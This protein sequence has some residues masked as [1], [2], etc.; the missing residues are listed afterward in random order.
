LEERKRESVKKMTTANWF[1]GV[2]RRQTGACHDVHVIMQ[3]HTRQKVTIK[4]QKL[5]TDADR[6]VFNGC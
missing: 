3:A 4:S 2:R 5:Q 6:S 1:L